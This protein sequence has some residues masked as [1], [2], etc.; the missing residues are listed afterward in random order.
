MSPSTLRKWIQKYG[1]LGVILVAVY[2]VLRRRSSL[3]VLIL[4]LCAVG[5]LWLCTLPRNISPSANHATKHPL[6]P[7]KIDFHADTEQRNPDADLIAAIRQN[8]MDGVQSALA[9][10]AN[11]DARSE[12]ITALMLAV[13]KSSDKI[14]RLLLRSDADVN[15]TKDNKECALTIAV[16]GKRTEVVR[17]L[18]QRGADT[19]DA[20]FVI[21]AVANGSKD[22]LELLLEYGAD[23]NA[24]DGATALMT[25][26]DVNNRELVDF[27]LAHK[28]DINQ[29]ERCY[30][31]ALTHAI[32]NGNLPLV[33]YLISRGAKIDADTIYANTLCSASNHP[34]ILTYL[35]RMG[36]DVNDPARFNT[37]PL[38]CAAADGNRA[39][40]KILL[41]HGAKVDMENTFDHET[42]LI[43]AAEKGHV[44]VVKLLIQWGAKVNRATVNNFGEIEGDLT[45][46]KFARHNGHQDVVKLLERYG[47]KE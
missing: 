32:E 39:C 35:L 30:G 5:A 27:L 3:L 4:F 7:H 33:K 16:H 45:A 23:I 41:K 43:V 47:A 36:V 17:M 13:E 14:V 15:A 46:L 8:H 38:Q 19:H 42:P 40:V 26:V 9:A 20:P 2:L 28:A 21:E 25:A 24:A 6:Q 34:E 29:V 1:N 10:G 37:T 44:E 31:S 22:I 18:L 11:V 12:G